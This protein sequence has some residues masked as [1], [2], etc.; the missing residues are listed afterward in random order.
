MLVSGHARLQ[1]NDS[2]GGLP[3][4]L[5]DERRRLLQGLWP[6]R[7]LAVLPVAPKVAHAVG[8]HEAASRPGVALVGEGRSREPDERS[9]RR[10]HLRGVRPALYLA[11]R[12]L[13]D[14]VG[15]DL[16]AAWATIR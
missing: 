3:H 4:R 14:V 16:E 5:H 1:P 6:R 10:E 12:P 8:D 7:R 9:G 11:V 2:L 15:P 13:L